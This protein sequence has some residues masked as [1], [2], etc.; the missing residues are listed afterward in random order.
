MNKHLKRRRNFS[1]I[2]LTVG[3]LML[4]FSNWANFIFGPLL[5]MWGGIVF[6]VMGVS[7]LARLYFHG[8]I[9]GNPVTTISVALIVINFVALAVGYHF[10]RFKIT[11]IC[12]GIFDVPTITAMS[13][14]I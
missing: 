8:D 11:A 13:K 1:M 4:V 7:S 14:L 9:M 2:L 3:V 12:L 10:D 6:F 5:M